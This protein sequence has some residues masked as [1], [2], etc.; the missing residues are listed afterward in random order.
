LV[1]VNMLVSVAR[2]FA[3][4]LAI[5][6][7]AACASHQQRTSSVAG[8][9]VDL[10]AYPIPAI[11]AS[12]LQILRGMSDADILGHLITVDSLEVATADTALRL[13]KSDEVLAYAKLTREN[14]LENLRRDRALARETGITPTPIFAGFK[15]THA[16]AML[17]SVSIASDTKIDRYYIMSQVGSDQ[18]VLGELETLEGVAKNPALRDHI[19][20]MIPALRDHLARAH[21]LAAQKGFEKKRA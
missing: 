18:H 10:S 12:E 9:S 6:V 1:E 19:A 8:G 17:D 5:S 14:A 2:P 20:T 4:M 16:A 11:D 13:S 21:A 7:F 15:T 3:T